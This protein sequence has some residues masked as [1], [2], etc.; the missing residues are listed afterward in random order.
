MKLKPDQPLFLTK[1]G[2]PFAFDVVDADNIDA[3]I[4]GRA[5]F[6]AWHEPTGRLMYQVKIQYGDHCLF[7]DIVIQHPFKS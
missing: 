2:A 4:I 5:T 6:V 7:G 3:G 1:R